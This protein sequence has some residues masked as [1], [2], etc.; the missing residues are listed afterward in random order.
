[1]TEATRGL[2]NR[3]SK[4]MKRSLR[5]KSVMTICAVVIGIIA[6]AR[7]AAPTSAE[8]IATT[9]KDYKSWKLV[10]GPF[11]VSNSAVGG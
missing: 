7:D 3:I 6:I 10:N 8:D 2:V 4:S 9:V 1:M 11:F 5:L